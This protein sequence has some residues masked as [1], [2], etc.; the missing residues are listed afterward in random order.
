MTG[1]TLLR[2]LLYGALAGCATGAAG[3]EAVGREAHVALLLPLNSPSF[4]RHADA[5]RQGF[6]AATRVAA[7]NAPPLRIYPV[8][9]D[10][11]NVLTVYEQA[12]ESGARVV[13]GPLTR[14][15][16]AALAASTLVTVP[17]LALNALEAGSPQPARLHTFSLNVEQEARRIAQ[18]ALA[19]GRRNAFVVADD[20]PLGRR[21]RQAFAQEF[22]RRGGMVAAEYSFSAEPAALSKLRPAIGLGVADMAFLALDQFAAAKVRPFL[23]NSIGLYGTS[24]LHGGTSASAREINLVRF[25]DMPWLLQPDHPAVMVYPRATF[26]DAVDFDRLYAFG[27]DAF[28]LA[29]E[30]HRQTR[31]PAIDGVTGRIRLGADGQFEREPLVAQYVD[32]R[33]AL[34]GEQR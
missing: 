11:L 9:E 12:L 33:I 3:G 23:G 30:L 6:A 1:R 27:V 2:A 24:R 22:A 25:T 28:R 5:V 10:T 15:G 14:A 4:G 21:M 29:L 13:V 18:L 17:T 8:N 26:G 20:S 7:K 19:D 16:V 31:N 32:G 34:I